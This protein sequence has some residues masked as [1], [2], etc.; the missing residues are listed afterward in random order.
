MMKQNTFSD[1]K[2][3]EMVDKSIDDREFMADMRSDLKEKYSLSQSPFE[4]Y[5]DDVGDIVQIASVDGVIK[6]WDSYEC[7][8][9]D[10]F[11]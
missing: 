9:E 4:T 3:H 7:R 10:G 5:V 2:F 1:P 6:M 11:F 8:G